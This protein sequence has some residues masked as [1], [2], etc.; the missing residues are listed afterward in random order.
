VRHGL[1]FIFISHDLRVIRAM[2]HEVLVMWQG[3]IVEQGPTQAIFDHP[4][5]PYTRQLLAAAIHLST[6]ANTPEA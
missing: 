6:V 2:S 5:H 4:Q 1:A 3:K